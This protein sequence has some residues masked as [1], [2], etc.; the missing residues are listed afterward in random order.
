MNSV[1]LVVL[2]TLVVAAM[3][4]AATAVRS[5]SRIWLRHWAERQIAG[6]TDQAA[7]ALGRPHQ[8]LLAAGT[9]I[10]A[11]VFAMGAVLA[12]R[13]DSSRLIQLLVLAA[14]LLLVGGQV[15]PR[16]IA[17]RW[18]TVC[19][20]LLM[21]MLKLL[22]LLFGPILGFAARVVRPL[23]VRGAAS[24][25]PAPTDPL[26]DLLREAEME[27]IGEASESEIISGVV[28]FGE[29]RVRDA[30]TPRARVTLVAASMPPDDLATVVAQSSYTRVPVVGDDGREVLGVLHALDV[31]DHPR[32]PLASLRAAT[33]ATLDEPCGVLM[34]R[35]LR[36]H[37]HLAVVRD[38]GGDI[39]GIITLEDL[40][41]ELVGEIRD[42]HD[43]PGGTA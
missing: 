11:V 14:V 34:R 8:Y 17:R 27:G 38:A 36:D 2:L 40:V 10:A 19:V 32:E 4:A 33:E 37:R 18:A 20:P 43:E 35:M 28:E 13:E 6:E 24:P 25:A 9:G 30:M 42:E 15:I 7:P 22:S 16:V 3:T 12:F 26:E 31:L 1:A 29:K 21:P 5:V 39:A 23:I 41:E